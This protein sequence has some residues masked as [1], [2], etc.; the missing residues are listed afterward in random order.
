MELLIEDLNVKGRRLAGGKGIHLAPKTVDL[1]RNLGGGPRAR[2]L[3]EHMLDE[4]RVAGLRGLFVARS[5][6]DPDTDCDRLERRDALN[7]DAHSIVQHELTVQDAY[8]G[9]CSLVPA[10]V[11]AG[12][13]SLRLRRILPCRSTSSTL[14]RI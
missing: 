14:T 1:T 8:P 12:M 13:V 10:P 11:G 6:I 3:E 5:G 9:V 2:S 4:M 7:H